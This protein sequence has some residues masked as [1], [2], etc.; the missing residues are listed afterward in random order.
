MQIKEISPDE[1]LEIRQQ[2]LWPD[3]P[4]SQLKLPEDLEGLH[5]GLFDNDRLVSVIS[6]FIQDDALRFR[7][8]ATRTEDQGKGYGTRLLTF[9]VGYA[10]NFGVQKIWCNARVQKQS[11]YESFGLI[12]TDEITEK[13]GIQYVTMEK[14]FDTPLDPTT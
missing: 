6:I 14:R 7:K 11:F 10:V 2:V 4:I 1:T 3:K 12:A 8:F 13:E 9:V 5:F